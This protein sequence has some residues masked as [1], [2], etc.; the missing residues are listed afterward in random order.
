[1]SII[2]EKKIILLENKGGMFYCVA[3]FYFQNNGLNCIPDVIVDDC[4]AKLL[5]E[6][7]YLTR[8]YF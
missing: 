2:L 8:A 7:I 5:S 6:F 4:G 1:M 3:N